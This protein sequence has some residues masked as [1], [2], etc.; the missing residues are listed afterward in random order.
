M[1]LSDDA[2]RR[3]A[4][5]LERIG[6]IVFVLLFSARMIVFFYLIWERPLGAQP[7]RGWNMHLGWGRYGLPSEEATLRWLFFAAFMAFGVL[8]LG[9]SIRISK[10]G[11]N[12]FAT[13][14]PWSR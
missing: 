6:G 9:K 8:C 14:R 10:L 13:T 7:D 5:V 4:R 3:L 1:T 12:V 2:W 11:E